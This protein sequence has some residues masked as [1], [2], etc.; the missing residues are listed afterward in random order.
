MNDAEDGVALFLRL[1]DDADR[2]K[3]VDLV[4]G[5]PCLHLSIDAVKMLRTPGDLQR[6]QIGGI[7]LLLQF[8]DDAFDQRLTRVAL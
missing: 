7:E 3:I 6:M 5:M 2:R 8:L 4:E 1:D